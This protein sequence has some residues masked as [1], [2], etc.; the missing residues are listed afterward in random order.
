M[1]TNKYQDDMPP[2]PPEI[3]CGCPKCGGD[4]RKI[5][6][7]KRDKYYWMC[8]SATEKCGAFYTSDSQGKPILHHVE[9]E[10]V[11]DVLCPQCGSVMEMVTGGKFGAFLS[12]SSDTCK[13]TIDLIDQS[14]NPTID[15]LAPICPTDPNHGHMKRR[16]GRNG[17]F[18]GCRAYPGCT[19][20]R[21]LN[22][23]GNGED[24][25]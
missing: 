21:Q 22:D 6:S 17:Q 12:C 1:A 13:M 3:K 2:K 19:S 7:K 18:W 16:G 15:N 4:L 8:M 20:T 11:P 24:D 9:K 14:A 23:V 5:F 25:E 10:P